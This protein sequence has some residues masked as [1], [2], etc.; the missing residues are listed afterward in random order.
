MRV[1]GRCC[2][3]CSQCTLL[4]EGK[5]DMIPCLLDQVFQRLK[6]LEVAVKEQ[7]KAVVVREE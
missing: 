7:N 5:V 3:D 1:N 2:E 6:R 4:Q